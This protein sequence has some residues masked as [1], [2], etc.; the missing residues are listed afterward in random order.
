MTDKYICEECK[1]PNNTEF[2]DL[3]SKNIC[4]QCDDIYC[5]RCQKKI[6]DKYIEDCE[7]NCGC[8]YCKD[9]DTEECDICMNKKC[10]NCYGSTLELDCCSSRC[11]I[12]CMMFSDESGIIYCETHNTY[13]C[14]TCYEDEECKESKKTFNEYYKSHGENFTPKKTP[15]MS[16]MVDNPGYRGYNFM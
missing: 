2:V 16:F 10:F 3:F 8:R 15:Y 14:K 11:C 4:Y 5:S 9:C 12:Q 13:H 1:K 7:I 6:N